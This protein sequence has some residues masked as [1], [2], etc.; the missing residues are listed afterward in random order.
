MALERF[1]DWGATG[2]PIRIFG[3]GRQMRDFTYVDDIVEGTILAGRY[4]APGD[5]YN[6][7][8]SSPQPLIE[9]LELVGELLDR[10]LDLQFVEAQ[11]GD[12]RDTWGDVS[13]A[14]RT[15]GYE[16]RVSLREGIA[17]Q[18]EEAA[19]RREIAPEPEVR[20]A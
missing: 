6:L 19:R 1:I 10:E 12:V 20:I 7:A 9:V 14:A 3:D 16:P 5:V 13:K 8:S 4:G 11:V 17:R 18:I 15:F 2:Q